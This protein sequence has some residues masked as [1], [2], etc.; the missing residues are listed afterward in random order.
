MDYLFFCDAVD[1]LKLKQQVVRL[2][3]NS[4][5]LTVMCIH[6]QGYTLVTANSVSLTQEKMSEKNDNRE[7]L[8]RFS[9]ENCLYDQH[10]YTQTIK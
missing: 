9:P 3:I 10:G 2:F 7:K 4:D 5:Y 1:E 6:I 8:F